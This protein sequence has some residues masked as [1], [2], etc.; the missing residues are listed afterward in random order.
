MLR[1]LM[2]RHRGARE[3]ACAELTGGSW[4]KRMRSG[5]RESRKSGQSERIQAQGKTRDVT[6]GS[7][8]GREEAHLRGFGIHE[9]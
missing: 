7:Q 8:A 2:K 5:G 6:N 9:G 4:C 3:R 1:S